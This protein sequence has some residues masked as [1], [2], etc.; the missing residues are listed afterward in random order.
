[1]AVLYGS[2]E[3]L[4]ASRAQTWSQDSF[5]IADVPGES[6]WFGLGLTVGSFG[7]DS[8]G[9][10]YADL[11][12]G[13]TESIN[14]RDAGAVHIIFGGPLGLG[15]GLG[16]TG[17]GSQLWSQSTPGVPGKAEYSDE[18]GRVL[19]AADFGRNPGSGRVDDLAVISIWDVIDGTEVT[20]ALTVLYGDRAGL[21]AR[22]SSRWEP[23]DFGLARNAFGY[24]PEEMTC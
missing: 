3:G 8:A 12:V 18:F 9:R 19:V 15:L 23:V 5:G 11:A 24:M 20:G 21:T 16:L 10:T 4:T 2:R 17:S 6:E 14:A 1:M 13:V 7:R 22:G